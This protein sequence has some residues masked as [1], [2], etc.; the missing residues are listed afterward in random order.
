[1][2]TVI[3]TIQ[4]LLPEGF[5]LPGL[6]KTAAL[7]LQKQKPNLFVNQQKSNTLIF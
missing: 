6:L 7:L 3:E 2:E 5:D 1:M 4:N